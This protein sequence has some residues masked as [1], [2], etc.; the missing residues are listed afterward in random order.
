MTMKNKNK[1]ALFVS[2]HIYLTE[3]ERYA[4]NQG[5]CVNTVGISI[6][7]WFYKGSTSEPAH[8]LFC[9]YELV[10]SKSDLSVINT[11]DQFGYYINLPQIPKDY[12]PPKKITDEEWYKLP[13]H[14]IKAY[15][16]ENKRP[17]CSE[18]L[19]NPKDGGGAYLAWRQNDI[20]KKDKKM[21]HITNLVHIRDVSELK[22]SMCV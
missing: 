3:A 1:I 18:R 19:L 9:D 17:L 11:T 13:P 4:L 7:V 5:T 15:Y 16:E 22:E 14:K 2:H 10:N 21:L 8:E 6:P 20:V 12:K